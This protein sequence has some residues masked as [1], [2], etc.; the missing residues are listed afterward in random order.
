MA[1]ITNTW[2]NF[3][4]NWLV[5]NRRTWVSLHTSDPGEQG[6]IS[7]EVVGG[8]YERDIA[9]WNA[10]A[11]RQIANNT[12]MVFDNMPQCIV[13]HAA[14][15]NASTFGSCIVSGKFASGIAV[16]D[17]DVF[18]IENADLVISL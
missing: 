17:G 8:T 11:S 3:V 9:S 18:V 7:T 5:G 6:D 12:V 2:G 4:L 14:V 16:S 15:W 1:T 13:T 10:S